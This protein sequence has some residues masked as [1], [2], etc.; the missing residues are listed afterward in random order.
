MDKI[1]KVKE[2]ELL[3]TFCDWPARMLELEPA[4]EGDIPGMLSVN[5]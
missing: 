1:G 2:R 5:V 4:F 3:K